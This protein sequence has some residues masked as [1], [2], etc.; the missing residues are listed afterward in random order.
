MRLFLFPRP[1]F[2]AMTARTY[3]FPD[4]VN[5]T[6]EQPFDVPSFADVDREFEQAVAR[7]RRPSLNPPPSLGDSAPYTWPILTA[8]SSRFVRF[9]PAAGCPSLNNVSPLRVDVGRT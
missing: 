7:G 5:G 6:M 1:A 4:G 9:H 2:E 8:T 3:G